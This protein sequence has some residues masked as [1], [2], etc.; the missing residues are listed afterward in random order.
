MSPGKA[1]ICR[2]RLDKK[3]WLLKTIVEHQVRLLLSG[4]KAETLEF[5]AVFLK[6]DWDV[7]VSNGEELAEDE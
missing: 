4:T 3:Q 5:L 2:N 1:Y 7:S 6:Q